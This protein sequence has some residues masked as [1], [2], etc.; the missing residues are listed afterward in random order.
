MSTTTA[1]VGRVG[2]RGL[3]IHAL[4]DGRTAT[5]CG[6]ETAFGLTRMVRPSLSDLD[7]VTCPRCRKAQAS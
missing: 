4:Q 1:R 2:H 7:V 6:A 3:T 5:V